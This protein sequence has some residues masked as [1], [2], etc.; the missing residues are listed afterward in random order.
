MLLGMQLHDA[1]G[2]L[3]ADA[4]VA[5]DGGTPSATSYDED[6]LDDAI[7]PPKQ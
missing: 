7:P 5:W 2:A 3:T 1:F 4:R 6:G